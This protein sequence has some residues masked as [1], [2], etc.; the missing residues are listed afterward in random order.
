MEPP[1]SQETV[2]QMF[3]EISSVY[4]LNNR[5]LSLGIDR[6]WR[7]SVKAHLP[8]GTGL[9]LLDL[10]TGTCDQLLLLM[11]T[12]KFKT[13][14]G[15]DLATKM[16]EQGQKKVDRSPFAQRII[17][18]EAS[19][20]AIPADADSFSCVTISFGIRNV[21]NLSLCLE[22][23]FRVLTPHGKALILEFS[24]PANKLMRTLHLLY[25]RH[26]L[27]LVGGM[28]SGK[29]GAYRYLNQTIESFPYGEAFCAE[30]KKVGFVHVTA[31]PLTFGIATLYVGEKR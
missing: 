3:N 7:K 20:L 28:I 1:G 5:I 31:H 10:A 6:Q 24:L 17:L 25:L 16:L 15:I 8:A 18:E 11:K 26:F 30:M 23:I 14:L 13:A 21:G 22:E 27:P 29:K 12:G 4:D 9:D 2:S 19:A